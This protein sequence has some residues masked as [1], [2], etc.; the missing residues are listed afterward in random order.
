ME[1]PDGRALDELRPIEIQT[2]FTQTPAASV[3][4]SM[5]NTVVMCTASLEDDVPPWLEDA[6]PPKGWVTGEYSM[7]PGSTSPRSRRERRKVGGRTKEIQRLIGRSLRGITDLEALGAREIW[8]DCDVLQADGGTRT[9]SVTGAFVALALACG[10][11]VDEGL[12]DSMPLEQAVAAVSCGVVAD[13]L[14]L[15]LPYEE[16]VSAD[17]DMNIVMTADGEFVEV[18]GTGEEATFAPRQLNGLIELAQKGVKVLTAA[19]KK[20]L[21][22]RP[23][24]QALFE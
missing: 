4:I 21:P 24:Y 7:L 3:L 14:R 8:L 9:A 15:D 1:R 13:T 17:V 6:E 22:D 19:Q 2:E 5:G 23:M 20:A 11:L 12:I 16:D 18:Q 10:G